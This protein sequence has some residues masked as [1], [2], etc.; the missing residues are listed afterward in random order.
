[1]KRKNFLKTSAFATAAVFVPV[2]E[3]NAYPIAKNSF[4]RNLDPQKI[5]VMTYTLAYQDAL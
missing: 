4:V 5:G 3:L 2:R 1:M